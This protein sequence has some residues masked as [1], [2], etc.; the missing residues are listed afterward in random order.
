V[1]V[2]IVYDCL[3]PFTIGGAEHWYRGLARK[4]DAEGH[5]VTYLTRDQW[6]GRTA[7]ALDGVDVVAVA[8][9]GNLYT[10]SGRRRIVPPVAFGLGVLI[11]LLRHGKRYD[12]VHTA[13]F[14][15]FPLLA[16]AAVRP[17]ARFALVVDWHE[18]WT[19]EY[20]TGYLGR[21][22]GLLGWT[23]QRMCARVRHQAVCFAEL[24]ARR[25]RLIN[26]AADVTVVRGQYDGAHAGDV[27]FRAPAPRGNPP[28][29]VFVGRHVP[30][31]GV[32]HLVPAFLAAR[33][34]VPALGMIIAGDGPR[35]MALLKTVA[36][37][38]LG[39][40]VEVPGF[41]SAEDLDDILCRAACLLLPSSREGYGLV[42]VEASARGCPTIVVDASD[43]AAVELVQPGA[44]GLIATSAAPDDLGEAIVH[45]VQEGDGLR[46]STAAW[47]AEHA[48]T[49]SL[50]HSVPAI[51]QLYRQG[52]PTRS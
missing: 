32:D 37:A 15:Y 9:G 42:V 26:G 17:A 8:G 45:V 43:N 40:V 27:T 24:T 1:R 12:V 11:H 18:V 49:L 39:D 5:E 14:P 22:R 50:E 29:V 21:V 46:Q 51:M 35:R 2:C 30:E 20:W 47:Y 3:Y 16:A 36:S 25:L 6:A 10:R 19:R 4:L 23:V 34:A 7:P 52:Q 38:G 48:V 33:E 41:V 31:K 44:N 13:S 28:T